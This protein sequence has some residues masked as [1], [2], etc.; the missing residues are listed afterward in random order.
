MEVTRQAFLAWGQSGILND[1]AHLFIVFFL[2]WMFAFAV[3]RPK[4]VYLHLKIGGLLIAMSLVSHAFNIGDLH[5][6][7]KCTAVYGSII[8]VL[9][10]IE[11]LSLI[12]DRSVA[13]AV[14][15]YYLKQSAADSAKPL[16]KVDLVSFVLVEVVKDAGRFFG[17]R[18]GRQRASS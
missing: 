12:G 4:N 15:K 7:L 8:L 3:Y 18:F 10:F 13:I 5:S 6:I 17:N 11:R 2:T 16:N 1:F 14:G 9:F